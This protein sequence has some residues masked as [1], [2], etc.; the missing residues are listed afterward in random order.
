ML[1]LGH[2]RWLLDLS[3][4]SEKIA[5]F[6]NHRGVLTD[7]FFT[8][9]Q[10]NPTGMQ[11]FKL[12]L[13]WSGVRFTSEPK[14]RWVMNC[15][16]K[17]RIGAMDEKLDKYPPIQSFSFTSHRIV[18]YIRSFRHPL[19]RWLWWKSQK[20]SITFSDCLNNCDYWRSEHLQFMDLK[21]PR[22]VSCTNNKISF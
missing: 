20:S 12:I 5:V 14:L 8:A 13:D 4:K 7:A 19:M 16:G 6:T 17:Q 2:N 3:P 15:R 18:V 21:R 22:L 1:Q 10:F 9:K 11:I